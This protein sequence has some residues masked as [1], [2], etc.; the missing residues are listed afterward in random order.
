MAKK[1]VQVNKKEK[2]TEKA[3]EVPEAVEES[4]PVVSQKPI[5]SSISKDFSEAW[6]LSMKSYFEQVSE[7]KRIMLIDIFC[8][9]LVIFAA[10]QCVFM[11]LIRSTFPFNAFLSS[12]I[13][14]VGQF[15]LLISLRLQLTEPFPHI[16]KS[17]AFG[18][19]IF[20]SLV[21]HFISLHFIN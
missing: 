20:A 6:G 7:D 14:C 19:F 1:E 15:V 9:F 5:N 17:R 11:I 18:E 10:L 2:T 21:L 3:V 12:F 8:L 4:K 16:S 13:L